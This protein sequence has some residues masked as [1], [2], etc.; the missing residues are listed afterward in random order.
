MS[1]HDQ[2]ELGAAVPVGWYETDLFARLL[3]K[4]DLTFGTGNL[5]LLDQV[6]RYEAEQ[7]FNRVLRL[8]IR[9]VTPT[10]IFKAERRLWT[11]FQDS[12]SW[13]VTS[14]PKGMQGVL[15]GWAVDEA[16]CIELAGYLVRLVEFTGGRN[17]RVLHTE[18]RARGGPDCVFDF[19]WD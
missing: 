10:Q 7:D 19:R 6:G 5:R 17:V 9:V 3:R 16:L 4:V 2:S 11:H 14:L 13:T 15:S 18:C 8:L 1:Q 12:G